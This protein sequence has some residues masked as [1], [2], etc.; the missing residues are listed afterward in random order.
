M[1][2]DD[3]VV[4]MAARQEAWRRRNP[5]ALAAIHSDTCT[6]DSPI[7]AR[8]TGRA[9]IEAS[10]EA[11]FTSF[12]DWDH[13]SGKPIIDDDRLAQYLPRDRDA[14]GEFMG[15]A[16]SGRRFEIHGVML[17]RVADGLVVEERRLYDFTGLLLQLGVLKVRPG[18]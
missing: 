12:P 18:K 1:T 11:L 10:Y 16:G 17:C 3:I 4:L 15:L 14:R 7:F 5:K 9:Q 13:Q 6:V 2:R 8:R